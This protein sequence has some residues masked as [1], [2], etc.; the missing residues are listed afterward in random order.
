MYNR[1][2]CSDMGF[3]YIRRAVC[4]MH[5]G[6]GQEASN[7][8]MFPSEEQFLEEMQ[9]LDKILPRDKDGNLLYDKLEGV[10]SILEC[11]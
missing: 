11:H 5:D 9:T 1:N 7:D 8:A 2:A 3:S 4:A 10:C 6:I